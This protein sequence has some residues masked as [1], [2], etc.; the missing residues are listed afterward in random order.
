M[1]ILSLFSWWYTTGWLAL[2]R[3]SGDRI[4]SVLNFFSVPL[5]LG[6][7]FAP[8]RQISAGRVQGSLAVQL[9]AFGDRLFSRFIGAIVR[10]LLII[11]GVALVMLI[12]VISLLVLLVWPCIPFAPLIGVVVAGAT[13]GP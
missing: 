10:S 8:F 2:A 1:I 6:S 5:L 9:Q 11:L 12:A 3:K 4:Q 7:L 13:H